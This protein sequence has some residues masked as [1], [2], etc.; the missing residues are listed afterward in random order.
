MSVHQSEFCVFIGQPEWVCHNGPDNWLSFKYDVN[1]ALAL[2]QVKTFKFA[3]HS[4]SDQNTWSIVSPDA[5]K[6]V[7]SLVKYANVHTH[8]SKPN[9]ASILATL[10]HSWHM[11]ADGRQNKNK[12]ADIQRNHL[13]SEHFQM[14]VK[15]TNCY[16]FCQ[17]HTDMQ[18]QFWLHMK[19]LQSV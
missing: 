1:E 19:D 15:T 7:I 18:K 17:L 3:F 16:F 2:A 10:V 12:C 4:N 6:F 13:D 5:A 9:L 8:K 11:L 14:C